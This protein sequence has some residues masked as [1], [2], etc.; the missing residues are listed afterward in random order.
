V[1]AAPQKIPAGADVTD[2]DPDRV[3]VN[4]QSI[5]WNVAVTLFDASIVTTQL[6]VPE[7][8]PDQPANDEPDAG[9]AVN[10]TVVPRMNASEQ[11]DPHTI[12]AGDELTEPDPDPARATDSDSNTTENVAVTLLAAS[13]VTTHDPVPEHAPDQPANDDATPGVAVSVTSVPSA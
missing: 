6:P 10:V 8:A 9:V 1:H 2:P 7:H 11:I 4:V 12:P 5:R 3:T 13:I